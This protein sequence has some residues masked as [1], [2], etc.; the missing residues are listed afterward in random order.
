MK[1]KQIEVLSWKYRGSSMEIKKERETK[2]RKKTVDTKS[3]VC[4]PHVLP[5][6]RRVAKVIQTPP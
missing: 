2:G 4:W 3:K 1:K 6:D 5:N